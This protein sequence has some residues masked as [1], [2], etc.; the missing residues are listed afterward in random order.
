MAPRLFLT[1]ATVLFVELL[2]IRWVPANVVYVGFF[3]NFVLIASFLGI[4]IGILLGRR[5]PSWSAAASGPLLLGLAVVLQVARVDLTAVDL[6]YGASDRPQL[7]VHIAVVSTILALVAATMAALAM[8]LA[9]LLRSMAPLRAYA[10]DIAG[11][12]AGIAAFALLAVVGAGPAVWLA[13]ALALV[14]AN[15]PAGARRQAYLGVGA[16]ALAVGLVLALDR[17][18]AWSPYYRITIQPDADATS[19]DVNGIPHQTMW[20]VSSD[21]KEP[22]YEQIYRWLPSR[23]FDRVLIIGAGTGTDAAVALAHGAGRVDA[24]EIDPAIARIGREMHP[25]RPFDDPRARVTI[26]DGRAY[27]RSSAERFDLIVYGSTDSLTLV[28]STAELRLES[29]L[30]TEEAFASVRDHLT[31]TGVF[32][33]YDWYREPWLVQRY[34]GMLERTFGAAPAV[35]LYP[36]FSAVQAAALA[37]GPGLAEARA[38][39]VA[40][41]G[42]ESGVHDDAP[43]PY[44]RTRDVPASGLAALAA[45]LALAVALVIA[46]LRWT[47]TPIRQGSAHFFLL[48]AAFM[49]LETKSLVTFSLLF[50]TTWVVNA[51]VFFA[52]L[53][54]VL[55]AVAVSVR[56]PDRDPRPYYAGLLAS[57]ALAFLVPPTDLL[58]EPPASRYAVASAMTFAPVFF[59]NL[60]FARSFRTSQAADVAFASNMLG[61]MVG[62]AIEWTALAIGYRALAI[63][64]AALYLGAYATTVRLP[65]LGDRTVRAEVRAGTT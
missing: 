29:F 31:P 40:A 38:L 34:A 48:G 46:A 23:R 8:P 60:V 63:V 19:I 17:G 18:E 47:S 20:S 25:D 9:G 21:K 49:L 12:M 5:L 57:L 4:G 30:Y 26:A 58:F 1:S 52:V 65:F 33:L 27:L 41:A 11:S 56:W 14:A 35:T 44:R 3:S 51:L 24:V 28:T 16:L 6:F 15:A 32:V 2:L 7:E 62:G 53:A 59:A 64:I 22:Y 55:A 42:A 36:T 43:F 45:L 54:S 61:A 39:P 37:A 50:G 13:V 10:V